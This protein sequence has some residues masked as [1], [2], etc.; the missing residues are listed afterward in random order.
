MKNVIG[1]PARGENFYLRPDE[2]RKIKLR[3]ESGAH[4]QVTAPRRVGK[5]SILMYF[6]DNQMPGYH[7]VYSDTEGINNHNDYF[8][9][10]YEEILR[11]DCVTQ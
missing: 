5:T 6:F 2:I 7:F 1:N 4:L 10:I 8:R 9:K 3:L 11:S